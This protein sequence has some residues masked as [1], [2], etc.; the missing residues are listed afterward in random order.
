M[1][2]IDGAATPPIR[3]GGTRPGP[4][5]PSSPALERGEGLV[6]DAEGKGP[7]GADFLT[8][9]KLSGVLPPD[10]LRAL[11]EKVR[12][13]HYPREPVALA[14]R[15]VVNRV[16]TE[17][18]ARC[19]LYGKGHRLAVGRYVI[20]DSI[21]RGAMGRVYK[22]RHALMDRVVALKVI[23]PEVA[24]RL[25]AAERFRREM[26]LVARLDHPN[27]IRALDAD[28]A[29]GVLYLVMEYVPGRGMDRL[30]EGPDRLPARL[31]AG[32]L[33]QAARGLAHAHSRGIV[34][35][36]VKPSNIMLGR[37]GRVLVLDFGLG[38]LAEP[39]A[40]AAGSFATVDGFGVGTVDFMSPEQAAGRPADPRS[41]QFAL[42]CTLYHLLTGELPFPG[43]SDVER[44]AA[45]IKGRPVPLELR[46]P[47]LP[48]GLLRVAARMMATR[49]GDRYPDAAQ[50]AEALQE[51]ADRAGVPESVGPARPAG[52]PRP[53]PVAAANS[54][55]LP[56]GSGSTPAASSALPGGGL[57][58]WIRLVTLLAGY[59]AWWTLTAIVA[60]LL[61]AFAS[62]VTL[63]LGLS[64]G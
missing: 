1:I 51:A 9:L 21:G 18:Q 7:T 37:D 13:G 52:S 20:L 39:G 10:Q 41:D 31:A 34:H 22:A 6:K 61:L 30:A 23:A 54:G 42:G 45:R 3:R 50:A 33:A 44:L 36:D 38:A 48:E 57:P 53:D 62:G 43:D 35:R 2:G 4:P 56:A 25:R 17:Y 40:G 5:D 26:R 46:R 16:L 27:V 58:R 12:L 19:L 29:A 24:S 14:T 11:R 15:L 28:Q 55:G 49:P 60:A 47:G 32:Y 64:R 59:P 63:C 8:A